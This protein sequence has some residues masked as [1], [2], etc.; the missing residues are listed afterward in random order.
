M[1]PRQ[2]RTV[3]VLG[4]IRS[5]KSEFAESL[6]ADAAAVRYVA[7]SALDPV[8]KPDAEWDS[9]I[10][11]HRERRPG[12]WTTEEIGKS[13]DDLTA[14][15]NTA[16]AGETILVDDIGGWLTALLSTPRP[17]VAPAI[18]ALGAAIA[19]TTARVVFVSPEV[20]LSVIPSTKL[21]RAF[22]DACGLANQAIADAC[23][24]VVF[25]VAG[26]PTWIKAISGRL[27]DSIVVTPPTGAGPRP[28]VPV[29]DF[30]LT[31]PDAETPIRIGMDAP[32]PDGNA[33]TAATD[34]VATLSVPGA[35]LGAL[36]P[37]IAFA[38]G[39]QGTERPRPFQS[40]RVMQ[41]TGSA[42]GAI[43]AGDDAA[44]WD[45]RSTATRAGES[46]LARLAAAVGA[47]IEI[48]DA[49]TAAPIDDNAAT[50]DEI[51]TALRR[52]WHAANAAADRGDDLIVLAAGGPGLDAAAAAVVAAITTSEIPALLGRVWRDGGLIDDNAWMIRCVAIRD[53]LRRLRITNGFAADGPAALAALGGPALATAAG[54]LLGAAT[55]RTPVLLDGPVGAAAALVS[56]DYAMQSRLWCLLVD[57]GNHPTVRVTADMLSLT[58]LV[59]LRMGLGEG[60]TSLALLPLMQSVLLISSLA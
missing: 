44:T 56:R 27:P 5:G 40:I 49:G 29:T 12:H 36:M 30:D 33:T 28:A 24:G 60:C 22:A 42:V 8:A 17:D 9:R 6:V 55:R 13:P 31:H 26:Q 3:L 4:G 46:P 48:I 7:T 38:A 20:G 10:A 23:D 14:L 54:V 50:G 18:D 34:R 1:S 21:G 25:V 43:A 32:V 39:A 16:D 57:D 11:A 19:D 53:A 35:G 45:A 59:D 58:P 37:V 47:P 41:I 2:P 52:G 15:I 51:E